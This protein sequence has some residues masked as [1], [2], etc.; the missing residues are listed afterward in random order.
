M[1]FFSKRD[2]VERLEDALRDKQA[3]REE[4]AHRLSTAEAALG[5]HTPSSIE[6]T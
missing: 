6:R 5:D 4:L 1:A 3:A 2:P